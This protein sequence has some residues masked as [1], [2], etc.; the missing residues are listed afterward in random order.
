MMH[1]LN[2]LESHMHQHVHKENN[3]LFPGAILMTR[4]RSPG[5]WVILPPM[6]EEEFG[7]F[8]I[9]LTV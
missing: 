3:V 6:Y 5:H 8:A 4:N 1:A 9:M 7:I 2:D